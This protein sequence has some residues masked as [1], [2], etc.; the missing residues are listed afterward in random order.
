MPF[1]DSSSGM[2]TDSNEDSDN[3]MMVIDEDP[4]PHQINLSSTKSEIGTGLLS[5]QKTTIP[6]VNQSRNIQSNI[7]SE[8]LY[9]FI[10]LGSKF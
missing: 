10:L 4:T 1:T 6:I 9:V 7:S 5:D 8:S 3:E 2:E